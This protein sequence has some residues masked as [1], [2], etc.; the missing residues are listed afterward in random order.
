VKSGFTFFIAL[1]FC[2][3][4]VSQTTTTAQPKPIGKAG[5]QK[6]KLSAETS[7]QAEWTGEVRSV[8]GLTKE[9]FT[10]AGLGRLTEEEFR[11]LSLA[12]YD[13]RQ[14]AVRNA[15]ATQMKY[16]CGP[17]PENYDRVKVYVEVSKGTASE[18]A[19]GA[20]QRLASLRD[21][22]IVYGEVESDVGLEFVGA[23]YMTETGHTLGHMVA[24]LAFES[25]KGS[26]GD[27]EWPFRMVNGHS[28]H[29]GPEASE[30]VNR[31]VSDIDTEVLE[32]VRK[33]HAAIKRNSSKSF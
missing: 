9:Q 16:Q 25:C 3:A 17:I 5:A 31:M 19:S 20:R 15:L 6:P 8:V 29:G 26:I 18:I 23:E 28:I 12:V 7:P 13:I 27:R 33:Q 30:L 4:S 1:L 22:Q 10:E 21:V 32:N 24:V 14:D 2:T 11:R